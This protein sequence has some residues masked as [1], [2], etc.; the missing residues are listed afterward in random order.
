MADSE[1]VFSTIAPFYSAQIERIDWL[2]G[3]RIGQ[4]AV[5][6]YRE[7]KPSDSQ[8]NSM[9]RRKVLGLV[10]GV[11][12]GFAGC[13]ATGA[14]ESAS[15]PTSTT[16]PATPSGTPPVNTG[17]LD[18]FD[19]AETYKHV[20]FGSR[21]GVNE[22]FLPHDLHICNATPDQR[23]VNLRILDRVANET[24]HRAAYTIPADDAL[25]V[26]LLEPSRYFV[27][28][29]GPAIA[30]ETL[31]VPC[32]LFDCNSSVTKIGVFENG[33]IRSSVRSTLAACP[34]P[35]C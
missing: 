8:E 35:D 5:C 14:G 22:D 7:F 18:D 19:P 24:I 3:L 12:S 21:V 2:V 13:L 31:L 6:P 30:T 9:N 26:T 15:N 10:G 29:W 28:L 1:N 20:E 25:A 34:S 16:P 11:S 23:V 17:G 33:H 32:D 27:Q 4:T